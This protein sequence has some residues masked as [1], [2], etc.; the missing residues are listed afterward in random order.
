VSVDWEWG[1]LPKQLFPTP[2]VSQSER[3]RMTNNLLDAIDEL[4][5]EHDDI[6]ETSIPQVINTVV[7]NKPNEQQ[8]KVIDAP[9]DGKIRVLAGPGAGKTHTLSLRIV[10]M[11]ESGIDPSS[12]LAVTFNKTMATEL[13]SR[14]SRDLASAGLPGIPERSICTIHAAC[15]RML[16]DSGDSRRVEKTWKV[17]KL[18]EE[19]I[20]RKWAE[21]K[22][23]WQEVFSWIN[24]PKGKGIDQ[25]QIYTWYKYALENDQLSKKLTNIH[26]KFNDTIKRN[27]TLTFADMLYDV[28]MRLRFD[29]RFL[30]KWQNYYKYLLIDEGQ[31]VSAQSM[32]IL[33]ALVRPE[34]G[35]LIVGDDAQLMFRFIGATPEA[36]L[37]DGFESRYPD[38]QLIKLNINYRSTETIIRDCSKLIAHNYSDTN[39][40][41]DQ[42]Y[43]KDIHPRPDAPTG[44]ST[45]FQMYETPED[46]AEALAQNIL[47]SGRKPGEIFVGYRT[48]AQA[49][50][51][52][53]PL[54]RAKIPYINIAGGSFWM[55]KHVADVIAYLRVAHDDTDKEAFKRIYNIASNDFTVPWSNS[56]NFG[57]YSPHRW[58]GK[59]FLYHC[60]GSY[61]Y[62]YY[63][64]KKRGTY[65]FGVNDLDSLV[66]GIKHELSAYGVSMALK[67]TIDR[68][69]KKWLQASE[70]LDSSQEGLSSV[71]ITDLETVVDV[72]RGFDDVDKFLDYVDDLIQADM[73]AQNKDWKDYVVISTVHRLKGL[74]REV[75]YGVGITEGEDV[76]GQTIGL[77][78]HTFSMID[79]PQFSVLPSGGKG[80][81]EDERCI[82]FV[83]CSRAKDEV[84]LSGAE[85]LAKSVHQPS[86]FLVEMGVV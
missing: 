46:E 3:I 82:M 42:K 62:I 56:D 70:G 54:L 20:D 68:C 81:I 50:F 71:K 33:T 36:N 27:G 34:D 57:K 80:R 44:I 74:E 14:I 47:S 7:T 28:E 13:Y 38:G 18:I 31:D 16:K 5:T 29:T 67:Y 9:F 51:L 23:N 39:G 86:R 65:K 15:Y 37:F 55:L 4:D 52:E 69:Y 73:D 2:S 10:K 41:Y 22:P 25:I 45:T 1:E 35:F 64:L 32:R 43:M 49:A 11:I 53:G 58:L 77:L 59:Q 75:V 26:R 24:M 60:N 12:I 66:T 19:L 76:H 48:R 40:P 61:K 78:P 79:P 17:K 30:E 83:L 84:H 85:F 63:A 72:A 8:Q 21:D 6:E